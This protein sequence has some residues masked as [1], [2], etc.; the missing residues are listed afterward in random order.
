ML[1]FFFIG[2]LI[3]FPDLLFPALRIEIN[4]KKFYLTFSQT[5]YGT[6]KQ[7]NFI[8]HKETMKQ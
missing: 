1:C 3:F 6:L 5:V 2:C 8:T 7:I 4:H